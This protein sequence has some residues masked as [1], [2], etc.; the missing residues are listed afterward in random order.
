LE[1]N[2][3]RMATFDASSVDVSRAKIPLEDLE[4]NVCRYD[5]FKRIDSTD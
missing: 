1:E 3:R 2:Y 5:I 4:L